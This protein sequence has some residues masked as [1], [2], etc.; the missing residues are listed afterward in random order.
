VRE[1]AVHAMGDVGEN[2]CV[3]DGGADAQ[4]GLGSGGAAMGRRCW[5]AAKG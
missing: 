1:L 5:L 4:T 3:A 2:R